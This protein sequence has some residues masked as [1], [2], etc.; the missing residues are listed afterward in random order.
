MITDKQEITNFIILLKQH[1][2]KLTRQQFST[3]RGQA[4]AGDIAGARKG[5]DK[6]LKG[7]IKH[8]Y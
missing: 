4:Y 5:L 2:Q 7:G 6:L 8:A 3:I 1:K